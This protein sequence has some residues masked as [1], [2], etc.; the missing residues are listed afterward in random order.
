M[1]LKELKAEG[2]IGTEQE[3]QEGGRR[4]TP[5]MQTRVANLIGPRAC[6]PIST[7]RW[8]ELPGS[9]L[10][11]E[12][13]HLSDTRRLHLQDVRPKV[14]DTAPLVESNRTTSSS[15]LFHCMKLCSRK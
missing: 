12:P 4:P 5:G 7:C 15:T 3:E 13:P 6:P 8:A 11:L 1:E 2:A 9:R 10:P 14:L